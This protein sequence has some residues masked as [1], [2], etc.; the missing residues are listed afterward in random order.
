MRHARLLHASAAPRAGLIQDLYAQRVKSYKPQPV[1]PT[2]DE[3]AQLKW[4]PPSRPA[5]PADEV[6]PS[7]VDAFASE[8]V[9]VEGAP[10]ADAPAFEGDWFPIESTEDLH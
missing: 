5:V 1:E 3:R 2:A 4:T 6:K 9:E 8:K 7:D 10:S